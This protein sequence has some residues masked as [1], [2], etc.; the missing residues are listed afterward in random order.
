MAFNFTPQ[1]NHN[2]IINNSLSHLNFTNGSFSGPSMHSPA[3]NLAAMHLNIM[4]HI[5]HINNIPT[6]PH[7]D[8]TMAPTPVQLVTP[9]PVVPNVPVIECKTYEHIP[10]GWEGGY[11]KFSI[12]NN[13]PKELTQLKETYNFLQWRIHE[14]SSQHMLSDGQARGLGPAPISGAVMILKS[15]TL[16]EKR[17]EEVNRAEKAVYDYCIKH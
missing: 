6:P 2:W 10:R 15:Q 9:V 7:I 3:M 8:V 13:E 16:P 11:N 1:F 12:H 4:D 17:I 14:P 5:N